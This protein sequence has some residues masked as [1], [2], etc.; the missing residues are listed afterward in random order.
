MKQKT[1][2]LRTILSFLIDSL[3]KRVEEDSE[4][5]SKYNTVNNAPTFL[6]IEGTEKLH[7][8]QNLSLK[9]LYDVSN[10]VRYQSQNPRIRC[11]IDTVVNSNDNVLKQRCCRNQWRTVAAKREQQWE[12]ETRERCRFSEVF[13]SGVMAS[14]YT[15]KTL[16]IMGLNPIKNGAS[17]CS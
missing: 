17:K 11:R 4:Q 15:A 9:V 10:A 8:M 13:N 12:A 7:G 16:E 5:K 3:K 1:N 6:M 14:V 2:V